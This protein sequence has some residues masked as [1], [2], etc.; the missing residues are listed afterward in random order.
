MKDSGL[1]DHRLPRW[2]QPPP[3]EKI[4]NYDLSN[5]EI[6]DGTRWD[7]WRPNVAICQHNDLPVHRL[8]MLIQPAFLSLATIIK[9][10]I[11]LVSPKTE[12][13]IHTLEITDPWDFEGVYGCLYD[14]ARSYQ[15]K[16]NSEE[17]LI[18]MSTGTH[19]EQICLFLLTEAKYLPGRLLQSSPPKY[20]STSI[21]NKLS[22]Q[23]NTN[24]ESTV[25]PL[26]P[27]IGSYHII[28]LDISRFN[29]LAV[30][31][32][33]EQKDNVSYLKVGINT[34]NLKFNTIIDRI[35]KVAIKSQE[36][37]LLMGE[38]GVGKSLLA[39]RIFEVRRGL[40]LLSGNFIEINCA[41]LRGEM[42][43]STLFGH[44]K[45][46]FTTAVNSR[47][48]LLLA[49]KG[50]VLF[51]DEIGEL[52]LDEQALLLRAIEDK[53]FMPIGSNEVIESNFQLIVGTN[54]DLTKSVQEGSFREDL[55]TR[56]NLWKFTL[57]SLR[58]RPEDIEPNLDYELANYAQQ[59]DRTVTFSTEAR[60]LF[61]NFATSP[62]AYWKGNFREFRSAITRMA[63]LAENGQIT[64][65]I[66]TEE[67][68]DLRKDWNVLPPHAIGSI[69][70]TVLTKER[71]H[72]ID[73][74]DRFTLDGVISTCRES[75]NLADA[76]RKLF[77]YSREQRGIKNDADRL[78]KFLKR[79]G[80]SWAKVRE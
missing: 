21:T 50:G 23:N 37:I 14:F 75:K 24:I 46:A 18:H 10:D 76:G 15:F 27:H 52:K 11:A 19:V 56:I 35:E 77:Q 74:F 25:Y 42:A 34:R 44:V 79:F 4:A 13:N 9:S 38:T 16:L 36:P 54:K 7:F 66:V 47:Q 78:S 3:T 70:G 43:M 65:D 67:I 22:K 61:L 51:L 2:L 40:N 20:R 63:T 1:K 55:F 71:L 80:L 29:T 64:V 39:K 73:L 41:T 17:Y 30:R 62:D 5:Q 8:E 68:T 32:H 58:D 45:G 59:N 72:T 49:A 48:G 69:S 28:D 53:R 26:A 12:V 60:R 33:K 57:P 31:L 6:S